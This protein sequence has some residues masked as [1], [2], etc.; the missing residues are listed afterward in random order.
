MKKEIS[1]DIYEWI[2]HW[3]FRDIAIQINEKI[4]NWLII[5]VN[6]LEKLKLKNCF[7]L[8]YWKYNSSVYAH[9]IFYF[10]LKDMKTAAKSV[11]NLD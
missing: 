4:R 5:N 10:S 9:T 6:N 3:N 11:V 2:I 8:F 7:E 1:I